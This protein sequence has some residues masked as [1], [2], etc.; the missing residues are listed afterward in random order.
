PDAAHLPRIPRA[1][2]AR[3]IPSQSPVM[4]DFD[5]DKEAFTA[6]WASP[7]GWRGWFTAVNNQPLAMRFILTAFLFF[8]LGGLQAMLMRVQLTVSDNTFIGPDVYNQLF[9]MHGSTMMYLFS[10]PLLEGLALYI[11]PLMLGS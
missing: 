8:L 11:L 3:G 10:V 6:L 4:P 1:S 5:R 2:R 7:P 9:T